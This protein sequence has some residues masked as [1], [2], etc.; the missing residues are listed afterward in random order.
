MSSDLRVSEYVACNDRHLVRGVRTFGVIIANIAIRGMNAY[1]T[2]VRG[3]LGKRCPDLVTLQKIGLNE[4]FCESDFLKVGYKSTFL[5]NRVGRYPTGVAILSHR[6]R[7]KPEELFRGLPGDGEKESDFLTVEF[8]GLWVSSVYV[9]YDPNGRNAWLDRLREHVRRERYHLRDCVLCGDFNVKFKAD[10]PRGSGYA[11]EHED[12]LK[13]LMDLGFCDL[14][15]AQ[16]PDPR[17]YPGRTSSFSTNNP[18]ITARLHL[19]LASES[20]AQRRLDVWLDLDSRPRD[21]AP[22][23]VVELGTSRD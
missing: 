9:P 14:Y 6:D 18:P 5:G 20:L 11:Q 7:G 4:E 13:E 16:Y 1:R 12:A 3:W 23:L 17:K 21:D 8:G 19:M 22:P 15:R 10:G 2:K